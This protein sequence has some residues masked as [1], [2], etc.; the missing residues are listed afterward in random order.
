MTWTARR[1]R[2][3]TSSQGWIDVFVQERHIENWKADPD[4]QHRII[5]ISTT[6]GKIYGLGVFEPSQED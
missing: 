1:E 4:G 6:L 5:E 3:P 2:D